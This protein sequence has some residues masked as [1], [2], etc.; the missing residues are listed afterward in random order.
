MKRKEKVLCFN[1]LWKTR[2]GCLTKSL[3]IEQAALWVE[4][5]NLCT[6]T[7]KKQK[8]IYI[9]VLLCTEKM[10]DSHKRFSYLIAFNCVILQ[11]SPKGQ[12]SKPLGPKYKLFLLIWQISIFLRCIFFYFMLLCFKPPLPLY[13]NIHIP[14]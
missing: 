7:V 1:V 6:V 12:N 8:K 9:G 3:Q 11:L 5:G 13:P 14:H 10:L 4:T 2:Y